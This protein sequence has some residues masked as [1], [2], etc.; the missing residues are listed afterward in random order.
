MSINAFAD[1]TKLKVR[2]WEKVKLPVDLHL[3]ET[4]FEGK[5]TRP[6]R[7]SPGRDRTLQGLSNF[8]KHFFYPRYWC[9]SLMCF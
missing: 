5:E 7:Y 8:H 9:V 6:G 2:K 1:K 4:R 3:G